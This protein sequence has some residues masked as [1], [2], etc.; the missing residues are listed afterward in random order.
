MLFIWQDR[1]RS[2]VSGSGGLSASPEPKLKKN[3]T[4]PS[5]LR[6]ETAT[7]SAESLNALLWANWP[8]V[9]TTIICQMPLFTFV[10]ILG[11]NLQTGLTSTHTTHMPRM[12]FVFSSYRSPCNTQLYSKSWARFNPSDLVHM[13]KVLTFSLL[14]ELNV[15]SAVWNPWLIFEYPMGLFDK[16]ETLKLVL[17]RAWSSLLPT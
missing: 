17:S 14:D 10:R 1:V 15:V 4:T 5:R 12:D 6:D 3:T 7:W 16:A 13:Q 11:E 8:S 9:N 2:A